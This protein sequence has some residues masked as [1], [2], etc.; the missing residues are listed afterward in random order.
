MNITRTLFILATIAIAP[1]VV[2]AQF[3]GLNRAAP[4][5]PAAADPAP[6]DELSADAMQQELVKGFLKGNE[7]ILQANRHFLEALMGKEEAA[8]FFVDADAASGNTSKGGIQQSVAATEASSAKVQEML[9]KGE[10]LSAEAKAEFARGLLPYALGV[11][12]TV[13]LQSSA[14]RFSQSAQQEIRNANIRN[15]PRL[16]SQFEG[17][18]YVVSQLPGY[19]KNLTDSTQS[20]FAFA[21]SQGIEVPADATA[22]LQF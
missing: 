20:I 9:S 1:A 12:E 18:L 8:K 2:S 16:R 17:G 4:S 21:S 13:Q 7:L 6:T 15:A 19:V 14:Q 11:R 22:A 3:G 10:E 5:A